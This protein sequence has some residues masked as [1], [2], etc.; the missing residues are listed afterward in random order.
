SEESIISKEAKTQN[1]AIESNQK[2]NFSSNYVSIAVG[3]YPP[4]YSKFM[5][6]NG[7]F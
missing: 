6:G 1:R 5:K 4:R 2:T 7:I 3:E